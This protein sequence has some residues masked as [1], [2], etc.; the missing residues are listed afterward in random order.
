MMEVGQVGTEIAPTEST[1]KPPGGR[2]MPTHPDSF[3]SSNE[4]LGRQA[5]YGSQAINFPCLVDKLN[6]EI[7]AHFPHESG[8]LREDARSHAKYC[9]EIE[10]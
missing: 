3:G 9:A 1:L 2:S 8:D 7:V 6:N 5:H 4:I 10:G